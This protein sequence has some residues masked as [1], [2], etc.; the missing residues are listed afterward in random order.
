MTTRFG[1][2]WG[3]LQGLPFFGHRLEDL[4]EGI[5][6]FAGAQLTLNFHDYSLT[7]SLFQSNS[8]YDFEARPLR[9]V[10][11]AGLFFFRSNW[12]SQLMFN[13]TS[14]LVADQRINKHLYL[15]ISIIRL[16]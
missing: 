8:L 11:Q 9:T 4:S 12:R 14:P 2:Q 16:F 10:F 6:F 5:A 15:N 7:G 1:L 3:D 13:Y